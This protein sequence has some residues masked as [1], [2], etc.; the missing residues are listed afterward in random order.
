[1]KETS[2]PLYRPFNIIEHFLY[3]LLFCFIYLLSLTPLR[4][5][6]V[7]ADFLYLI[8]YRM[9][10]YRTRMVRKNLANSF[11]EKNKEE[12]KK[13]EQRF[14]HFL[15]NYIVE[16]IKLMSISRKSLMRR[17]Q[18][19]DI[20]LIN[21]EVHKGKSVNLFMGHYGNWEWFTVITCYVTPKAQ[22]GQIYHP[23]ENKYFDRL[24]LHIRSRM[25]SISVP[26]NEILR[27]RIRYKQQG[28]PMVMGYIAD[29]VP[30]WN[31]IHYWTDFLHQDT[32]VLTGAETLT[33]RFG[34]TPF[35]LDVEC[36]RRGYYNLR[37]VPL[38]E[39]DGHDLPDF[40]ITES[41]FRALEKNI[42]RQPEYWLWSHNRWKRTREVWEKMLDPA[43]GK[44][45][46]SKA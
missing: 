36:P 19:R 35:V 9:I 45:I 40:E 17:V 11:P 37:I 22:L 23:L 7:L 14:Y 43:T 12:L 8:A 39:G 27:T 10:G 28:R 46:L 18:M 44:I 34:D 3:G 2:K 4:I 41:Y 5:L 1:M 38:V 32:P 30:F 15:C 21:D 6:Y 13:I 42:Q 25:G 26:M 33:K 24:F 31:N 16:T 29:Q 20:H